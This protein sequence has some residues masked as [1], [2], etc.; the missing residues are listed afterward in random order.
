MEASGTEQSTQSVSP[1]TLLPRALLPLYVCTGRHRKTAP[2]RH[3][4]CS[5]PSAHSPRLLMVWCT[6]LLFHLQLHPAHRTTQVHILKT[7]KFPETDRPSHI[8]ETRSKHHH[9]PLLQMDQVSPT[10]FSTGVCRTSCCSLLPGFF[11][12][13]LYFPILKW[14]ELQSVA[15]PSQFYVKTPAENSPHHKGAK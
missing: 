5:S 12:L 2:H 10:R 11:H 13:Q 14:K 4:N 8:P 7:K 3:K 15:Q 9:K 6:W 1:A